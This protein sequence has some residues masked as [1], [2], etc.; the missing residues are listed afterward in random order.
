MFEVDDREKRSNRAA[1]DTAKHPST[2]D[3]YNNIN[4]NWR[5]P[6]TFQHAGPWRRGRTYSPRYHSE[7]GKFH[8]K[9]PGLE[10]KIIVLKRGLKRKILTRYD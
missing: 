8:P 4:T 5:N 9:G 1:A 3:M 10:T 7:R 6:S 2:G